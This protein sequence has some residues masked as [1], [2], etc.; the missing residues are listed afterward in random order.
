MLN[1]QYL[2]Q[3]YQERTPYLSN[4]RREDPYMR[5]RDAYRERDEYDRDRDPYSRT[6]RDPL[7]SSERNHDLVNDDYR[8]DFRP[9]SPGPTRSAPYEYVFQFY[10]LCIDVVNMSAL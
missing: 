5:E 1:Y 6:N 10:K 2:L 9:P 4:S 8:R 3:I 7:R